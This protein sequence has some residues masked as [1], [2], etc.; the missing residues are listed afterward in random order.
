QTSQIEWCDATWNP[1]HG[2]HKVSPGCQHCYMYSDKARYGQDPN[3]VVRSKTTFGDP[4]KWKEPKRIFTCSCANFFIEEA[5]AWRDEAWEIIRQ[6][7]QHTYLIL[8]KRPERLI[9]CL[10]W[11][12]TYDL[13]PMLCEDPWPNVWLGITAENQYYFNVRMHDL[14]EIP[15]ALRF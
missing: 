6:T 15:C 14:A 7:P 13:T 10:P 1:W 9:H 3:T 4:L 5:D 2:C 12:E 11:V 8:T